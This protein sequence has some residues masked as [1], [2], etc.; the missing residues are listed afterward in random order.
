MPAFEV[1]RKR[2][3]DR[4]V[5]PD[6]FDPDEHNRVEQIAAERRDANA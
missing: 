3:M 4:V 5:E 2:P 6:A 1:L